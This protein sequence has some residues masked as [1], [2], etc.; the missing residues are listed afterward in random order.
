MIEQSCFIKKKLF[1]NCDCFFLLLL[2]IET[3]L[4][5]IGML[6]DNLAIALA[7]I[8]C[9]VI[10]V[11]SLFS[12]KRTLIIL[13]PYLILLPNNDAFLRYPY[14]HFPVNLFFVAALFFVLIFYTLSKCLIF[15]D[16]PLIGI[17]NIDKFFMLFFIWIIIS[18]FWG[19]YSG[20]RL[21]F[22]YT[23][24]F[25]IMFYGMYFV[26]DRN[27]DSLKDVRDI[28]LILTVSTILV[29]IEFIFVAY[30][31]AG[32]NASI[33]I[34]RISSQQPH[35]AQLIIPYLFSYFLF[36]T[37]KA[38]IIIAS[39]LMI[40]VFAMVF[41]SQQRG[42]WGGIVLSL[43]ILWVFAS[44]KEGISIKSVF[45]TVGYVLIAAALLAGIG[46]IIDSFIPGSSLLTM[47][48]RFNTL[49]NLSQDTSLAIRMA[50]I[51]RS[52]AQW[53]LNPLLGTGLGSWISPVILNHM[54]FNHVDNSYFFL[55]WKT[56]V[57][58]LSLFLLI[59]VS[60]LVAG[61]K[62]F[63][64]SKNAEIKR[65]LAA[66]ISGILGLML[67]ALTNTCIVY[68]GLNI[69]WAVALASII[70]LVRLDKNEQ[71]GPKSVVENS[72]RNI[73]KQSVK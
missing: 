28:W 53:E 27:V 3:V 11:W 23:E 51:K 39:I 22:I 64:K 66:I 35:V 12:I 10:A 62:T 4:L 43:F 38:N 21:K 37:R 65:M 14:L 19:Y 60:C 73:L 15:N 52:V 9:V 8:I 69:V 72:S 29:S 36:Q 49:L 2:F 54:P 41:F 40:P 46:L 47:I 57:V 55:L 30:K 61:I 58:G 13:L 48:N 17:T 6:T 18:I 45:K 44:F 71:L 7:G 59:Y 70:V 67:I 56:G 33:L 68:Y 50:E 63:Y 25:F 1:N 34:N 5:L 31:E 16:K 20:G 26:I 32:I 42:L 24:V